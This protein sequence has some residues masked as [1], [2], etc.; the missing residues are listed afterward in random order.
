VQQINESQ[1]A[2]EII[3][4]SK[5]I[6]LLILFYFYITILKL[7]LEN[8]NASTESNLK[9]TLEELEQYKMEIIDLKNKLDKEII[10]NLGIIMKI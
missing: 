7:Y 3:E 1:L 9:F 4:L 6:N 8:Q 10:K 5:Y 2:K